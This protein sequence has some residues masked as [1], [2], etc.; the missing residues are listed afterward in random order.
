MVFVLHAFSLQFP[1]QGSGSIL[2]A[3]VILLAAVEVDRQIPQS[4]LVSSGQ[5][6]NAVLLPMWHV[7]GLAESRPQQSARRRARVPGGCQFLRSLCD[8]RGALGADRGK[9][10]GIG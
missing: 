5:N 4:R 6:E 1:M 10:L 3:E 9:Q 2:E 8:Q 7:D